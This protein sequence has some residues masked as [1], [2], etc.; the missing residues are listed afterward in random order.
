MYEGISLLEKSGVVSG[1]HTHQRKGESYLV[2][3]TGRYGV[4]CWI[5]WGFFSYVAYEEKN[6]FVLSLQDMHGDY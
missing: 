3:I 5:F 1:T 6:Y 2:G 4:S